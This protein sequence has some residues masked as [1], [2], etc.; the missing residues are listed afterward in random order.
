V[1]K[2]MAGDHPRHVRG[3]IDRK[4]VDS[5]RAALAYLPSSDPRSV[6]AQTY[7]AAS[8]GSAAAEWQSAPWPPANTRQRAAI[9]HV[10]AVVGDER[11]S[12]VLED[13]RTWQ[14]IEA[15]AIEGI[16]RFRQGRASDAAPLIAKALIAYRDDPWPLHGVMEYALTVASD[17]AA[18][19]A[20]ADR[21]I[22][23]LAKPYAAYQMEE[24]RRI[25]YIAA[26]WKSGRCNGRTIGAL[27]ALEPHAS[28]IKEILQMRALCYQS[29]GLVD[30]ARQA[31][32][33]LAEYE[34]ADR[35]VVQSASR[36]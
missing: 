26:A 35:H 24:V 8:F 33:E 1:A 11:A 6:F 16:L 13:L 25:A 28:W 31:K 5:N 29:A 10:L 34:T 32:S 17:L 14:P 12:E 9:A 21:I 15:D 27:A 22:D 18:D 4:L 3:A 2:Q 36:R 19:P 20:H 23:A 7:A 30:L